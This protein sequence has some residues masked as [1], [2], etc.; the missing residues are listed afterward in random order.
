MTES[1]EVDTAG[2]KVAGLASG[3]VLPPWWQPRHTPD[4]RYL[5]TPDFPAKS[6][7]ADGDHFFTMYE[8]EKE[9]WHVWCKFN[10]WTGSPGLLIISAL[11][12][13]SSCPPKFPMRTMMRIPAP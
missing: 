4:C 1:A 3:K 8:S 13:A 9:R 6:R 5:A 2:V 11:A 7:G 12:C 10:F